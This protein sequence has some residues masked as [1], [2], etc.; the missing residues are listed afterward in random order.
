[1][2]NRHRILAVSVFGDTISIAEKVPQELTNERK[3]DALAQI[4]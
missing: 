4:A 3:T 1:V 2:Q